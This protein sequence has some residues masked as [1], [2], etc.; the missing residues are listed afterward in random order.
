MIKRKKT[1]EVNK[2]KDSLSERTRVNDKDRW[3][4]I[5]EVAMVLNEL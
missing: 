4:R 2:N 3:R 1:P 5:I